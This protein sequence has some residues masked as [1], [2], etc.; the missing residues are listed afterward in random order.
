MLER[1][2]VDTLVTFSAVVTVR[3]RVLVIG[4]AVTVLST[5]VIAGLLMSISTVS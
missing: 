3:V 5:V 2:S 4:V 1:S